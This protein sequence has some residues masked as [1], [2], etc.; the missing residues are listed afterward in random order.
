MTGLRVAA[1]AV[2]ASGALATSAQAHHFLPPST[3]F[4]A[5]GLVTLS[6]SSVP[7]TF[8][9]KAEVKGKTLANFKARIIF[10]GLSGPSACTTTTVG[11]LPW[12]GVGT[13]LHTG[14]I[15]GMGFAGVPLGPCGPFT[16]GLTT[17]NAGHWT[18]SGTAGTC[19]VSGTLTT[20]PPI[21][22][23]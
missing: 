6:N 13:A 14:T 19:S 10:F 17:T 12:L 15:S 9:C 22:I 23:N 21:H 8:T 18:Y 7:V 16:L 2:L 3:N 1:L 20:T 4:I 5:G 11:G